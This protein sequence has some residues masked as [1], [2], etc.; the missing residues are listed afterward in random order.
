MTPTEKAANVALLARVVMGW[1][2]EPHRHGFRVRLPDG[3]LFIGDGQSFIKRWDPDTS[4]AD[5]MEM[6]KRFD[7][8]RLE[9]IE[10]GQVF[11]LVCKGNEHGSAVEPT[12]E[13]AIYAACLEWARAQEHA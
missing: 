5:A 13:D 6:L 11:C 4:I 3:L 10:G 2:L 7:S 1:Q 9:R 12:E 8:Y